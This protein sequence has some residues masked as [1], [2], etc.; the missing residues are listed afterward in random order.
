M[1]DILLISLLRQGD[2]EAYKQLYLKY[3]APLCE[4]AS[5]FVTDDDAEDLVQDFMLFIWEIHENLI[6]EKSLKS[7]LFVSIKHRCINHMKK[8]QVYQQIQAKI[9]E[10]I[11]DQFEDPDSYLINELE[12]LIQKTISELPEKYRKV[13]TMSRYEVQTN[14]KIAAKLGISVK[15]VEYRISQALKILRVKLKDYRFLFLFL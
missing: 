4:Y 13:F 5:Q 2:A 12:E 3:Y 11:K 8:K 15:T 7:Y 6:I 10:N 1:D 9:Y 14:V